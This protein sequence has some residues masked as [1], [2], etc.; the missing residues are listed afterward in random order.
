MGL[1]VAFA[2]SA[3][4][5][6]PSAAKEPASQAPAT[7]PETAPAPDSAAETADEAAI[8]GNVDAFTKAYDAGNA[9]AVAALFMPDAEIVSEDGTTQQGGDAIETEFADI[10][11]QYPK[12]TIKS[13]VKSIRF[14][15]PT[16]AI[17]EG[18]SIVTHEPNEPG[19]HS[20]YEVVH[21]KQAGKWLMASARDLPDEEDVAEDNLNQL[22]WLIGDWVDEDSDAVVHTAYRWSEN[23]HFILC[24]FT[25]NLT[26]ETMTGTQ[27]IG[28]DPLA[29]TI[30]SWSFDSE[31]GFAEATWTHAGNQWIVKTTGVTN[32]GKSAS[33]T[34][35]MTRLRKHRLTWESRDRVIGGEKTAD[36]GPITIARQPPTPGAM[37][38]H[39]ATKISEPRQ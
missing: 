12:A 26:G 24:D 20:R 10:F 6:A 1:L 35:Y 31:G 9:K 28:W 21:V 2:A 15:S 37:T 27:R 7:A 3:Q 32:D 16:L 25:A 14:V 39:S 33:S 18:T 5:G 29:K 13:D 22:H 17:E 36:I 23:H 38:K 30:R 11:K 8:R 4:V 34:N 19:E